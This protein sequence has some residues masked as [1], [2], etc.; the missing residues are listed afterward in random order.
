MVCRLK[1]KDQ[2]PNLSRMAR[3]KDATV[4]QAVSWNGDENHWNITFLRSPNDLEE[5]SVLNL[6]ALLANTKAA[7]MGDDKIF[8]PHDS[9]VGRF[10]KD[11]VILLFPP[12]QSGGLRLLPKLSLWLG[13]YQAESAYRRYA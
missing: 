9:N 5:E 8:R 11:P 4:Q 13:S 10:M 12:M 2:F 3:F 6:L 1:L 7:P